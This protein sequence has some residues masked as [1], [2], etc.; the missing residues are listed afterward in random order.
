MNIIR[1]MKPRADSRGS[2]TTSLAAFSTLL[3]MPDL[4]DMLAAVELLVL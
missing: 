3:A 4:C 2:E 1:G